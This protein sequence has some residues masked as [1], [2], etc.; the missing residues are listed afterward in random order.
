MISLNEKH[1]FNVIN[2]KFTQNLLL[3]FCSH[4]TIFPDRHIRDNFNEE[5]HSI[6]DKDTLLNRKEWKKII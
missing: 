1:F 6:L 4:A 5:I 2:Y 3:K